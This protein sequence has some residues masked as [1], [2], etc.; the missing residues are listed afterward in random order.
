MRSI[1]EFEAEA[2]RNIPV[3]ENYNKVVDIIVEQVHNQNGKLVISGMGKA[4]Q[5][6]QNLATTFCST[7]T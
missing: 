3:S 5:V 6:G 2:I 7:G 4:G 1:L